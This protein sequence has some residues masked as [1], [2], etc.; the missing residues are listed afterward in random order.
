MK[1]F[2]LEGLRL[3][4]INMVNSLEEIY[5]I[6]EIL[7]D[8]DKAL[9]KKAYNFAKKAHKGKMKG[10]KPFFEHPAKVGYLLAKWKQNSEAISAGLLHDVVEDTPIKLSE[11]RNK[12]GEKIAFYVD[13]M[14][15]YK[16]K[17]RGKWVEDH[18][19]L[20]KRTIEYT[21]QD[22]VLVIIRAAD[23]FRDAPKD[24][25]KFVNS[26]KEKG[27][28]IDFQK[29]INERFRGFWI[30]FFKELGLKEVAKKIEAK[31]N[32]VKKKKIK[33]TLYNYISKK[34]LKVIKIKI[35]KIKGLEELR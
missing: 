18:E 21:K 22:P 28:W 11:I 23:M 13:G 1:K 31:S 32:V 7:S 34:D 27:I 30:P 2:I 8:K 35:G 14:S 4:K 16:K 6:R 5:K 26:L 20:H 17:F 12:F 3:K 25:K 29:M 19:G 15:W 24:R 9:I 33:I 10:K